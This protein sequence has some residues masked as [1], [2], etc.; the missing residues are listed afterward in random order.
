MSPEVDA[1][2]QEAKKYRI[3]LEVSSKTQRPDWD[4][5]EYFKHKL[6]AVNGYGY[7]GKLAE[8]LRL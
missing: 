3:K 5:Y 7:E 4:D 6:H 8:A 1:V 2:I